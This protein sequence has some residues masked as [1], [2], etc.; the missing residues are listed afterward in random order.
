MER[1]PEPERMRERSRP[2]PR[3]WNM[4]REL[5]KREEPKLDLEE[6][7][8]ILD[9]LLQSEGLEHFLHKQLGMSSSRTLCPLAQ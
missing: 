6:K 1:P 8:L 3:E 2:E 5:V 4:E 7:R 9:K